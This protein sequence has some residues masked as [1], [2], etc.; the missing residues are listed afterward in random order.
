MGT[1]R[2][3]CESHRVKPNVKNWCLIFEE[4]AGDTASVGKYASYEGVGIM[5]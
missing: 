5:C 1:V 2:G 4:F 3:C